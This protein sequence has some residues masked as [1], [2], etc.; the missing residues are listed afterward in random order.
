M[1]IHYYLSIFPMEALIAS[2]LDPQQFGAYMATGSKKASAEFIIF[3]EVEGEFKSDFD[4]KYAKDRCKPHPGGEPKHSVY[5]SVYRAFEHIP[6]K[7]F[8]SLYLT[9]RDGRTLGLEKS[10]YE[11]AE[12]KDFYVYQEL[13]PTDPMVVSSLAP[14]DFADYLTDKESKIYVPG[15]IFTDV[16]SINFDDPEH[17]GNIGG[18]FSKNL[19]HL[20]NCIQAVKDEPGKKSKTVDRSH[21]ESFSYQ[22]INNGI[23]IKTKDDFIMYKMLSKGE[24]E[25]KAY[26]WGRSALI[27]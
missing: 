9:T 18:I 14:P 20:K 27:L 12:N 8:K 4:W 5:L 17:T 10:K 11:A 19:D 6:A 24:I 7:A 2:E 15:I 22:L 16:I 13:C 23:Y 3:A 21:V 26:D 1:A 25:E